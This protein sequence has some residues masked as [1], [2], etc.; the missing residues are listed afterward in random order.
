MLTTI[1][2]KPLVDDRTTMSNESVCQVPRSW[3]DVGTFHAFSG[4][5]YDFYSVGPEYFGYTLLY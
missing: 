1:P 3:V 5:V 4:D 2:P